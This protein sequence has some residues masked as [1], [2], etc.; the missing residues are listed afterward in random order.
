MN[1][2]WDMGGIMFRYFTEVLLEVGAERGWALDGIPLG[3]TGPVPDPDY[4]RMQEGGIDEPSYRRL[5]VERL[6]AAGVEGDPTRTIDWPGQ[7]RPA[8]WD[9]IRALHAAGH[10]QAVLTNDASR[11]L[12]PRWWETW[13]FGTWFEALVD[14]DEV[15]ERKPAP[16]PYLAAAKALGVGPEA[17]LFI[18]D[19]P[20]NC[21]GAE[22]V[23]MGSLW[24]D[25]REPDGSIERLVE[26]LGLAAI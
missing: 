23:G 15:G 12:G 9:A 26:R 8:T 16:A 25:V 6:H 10:P 7:R 13:E 5:V 20:V 14:V 21:R 4:E 17:C 11:W 22:A 18:D 1:V 19:M 2:V 3:P 24:F